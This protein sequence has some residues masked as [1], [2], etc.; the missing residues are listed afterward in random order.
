MGSY[1]WV[2]Q[3]HSGE[4]APVVAVIFAHKGNLGWLNVKGINSGYYC[5]LLL[6]MGDSEALWTKDRCRMGREHGNGWLIS[7]FFHAVPQFLMQRL[8]LGYATDETEEMHV[9]SSLRAHKLIASIRVL[10]WN[11][12]LGQT[13]WENTGLYL[14]HIITHV[15]KVRNSRNHLP[16]L[17]P[18]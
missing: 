16:C 5:C 12:A 11:M 18:Y 4:P 14:M 8:M 6:S 1:R 2:R 15:V 3:S 7:P 17:L 9:F 10:E 13:R